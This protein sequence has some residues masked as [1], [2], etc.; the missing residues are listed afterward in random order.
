M[1]ESTLEFSPG[2]LD[3]IT[4]GRV[5][6]DLY[7]EQFGGRLADMRSFAKY[8]GGCPANIAIGSSRLGLRTGIVTGVGDEQFGRFILDEFGRENVSTRGVKVD[9]DRLSALAILGIADANT[10]PLLFYRENCADMAL[11]I[12]DIDPGF[13]QSARAVLVSGTHFSTESTRTLS[14]EV[15]RL[16][17]KAGR[18]VALDVDYRPVLWGLTSRGDGEERFIESNDVTT[19]MQSIVGDCDLIVGTEE[20]LQMLGGD[21]NT[22]SAIRKV[23][24]LTGALIV[25][26]RGSEGCVAF[27]GVIADDFSNGLISEGFYVEVFNVLGAG[28]AFL[29]GFLSGWLKDKDIEECCRHANAAGAIVVSRHGCAPAIPTEIE[30]Q[31]FLSAEAHSFA[32]RKDK[33]LT[34]TH[35]ATT[36]VAQ[37][38]DLMVFAADH[39]SQF[40]DLA[41]AHG[42][43]A[44]AISKF[45]EFAVE[46]VIDVKKE[47]TNVGILMDGRYGAQALARADR[48][49][50]WIGRPI[51]LPGSRPLVFDSNVDI[52]S[53]LSTW[54]SS[55]IVKCLCKMRPDD[56]PE[57]QAEQERQLWLLFTACRCNNLE[58]LLE[59]ISNGESVSDDTGVASLIRRIYELGIYP[60][61]WKLEPDNRERAWRNIQIEISKGDPYCRGIL[62]LGRSADADHLIESFKTTASFPK[63][64][65]F[66]I[67]RTIFAEAAQS[68]FSGKIDD[69]AVTA[70]LRE[71]FVKLIDGW[72]NT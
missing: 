39:R 21:I 36:R 61:W 27:D 15:I 12:E 22:L 17:R 30:L 50:L 8:I 41:A 66:A 5:S 1:A 13:V 65:G 31:Q 11:Q 25:C 3:L 37:A 54:P 57:L 51:E 20:E 16:A 63:I 44:E 14:K 55:N 67:G 53:E 59:I 10:F 24:T 47:H 43:N 45:K 46:A 26:K 9:P 62:L 33:K 32:L 29:S 28:D 69:R 35:W 72:R 48:N 7:G 71:N 40:E 34:Q 52:G 70:Q 23:R 2:A 56:P 6:V 42:A 38:R 18:K 19:H 64:R 49:G 4:V 68:W 58:F 60:D